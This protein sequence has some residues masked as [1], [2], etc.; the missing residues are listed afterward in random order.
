MM[1]RVVAAICYACI[2]CGDFIS[3]TLRNISSTIKL[4]SSYYIT[5]PILHSSSI[6]SLNI[7]S[8]STSVGQS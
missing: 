4:M 6:I 7:D 8:S 3:K 1:I 2:I 5:V